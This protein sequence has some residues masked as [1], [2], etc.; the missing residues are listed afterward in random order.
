MKRLLVLALALVALASIG[1][2]ETVLYAQ[3]FPLT[4]RATWDQPTGNPEGITEF[5]MTVNG[6]SPMIS[7]YA[8]VCASNP[9]AFPFTVPSAGVYTVVVFGRNQWGDGTTSNASATIRVPG[10]STNVKIQK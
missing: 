3:S 7:P 8:T 4:V 6:G 1:C 9:C 5:V 10:A 2:R